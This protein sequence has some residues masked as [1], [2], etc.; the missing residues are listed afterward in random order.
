MDKGAPTAI[1]AGARTRIQRALPNSSVEVADAWIG[2]QR[3]AG[4]DMSVM[5]LAAGERPTADVEVLAGAVGVAE[6]ELARRMHAA[7]ASGSLPF[8]GPGSMLTARSWSVSTARRLARAG[9]LAAEHPGLAQVWASGIITS[10]HV[11]AVARHSELFTAEELAAVIAELG[12]RWGRWSPAAITRFVRAADRLLHPRAADPEPNESDAYATRGLSFAVTSD[13]VILSGELPR[14]EGELVMAA[15]EA[16]AEKLRSTAEHVPVSARR[17]D[18]L[19]ELVNAAHAAGA[20]PTRGGLPVALTVTL[21]H[22]SRGDPIWSTGRGHL[23]TEA[24]ARFTACDP[25]ITPVLFDATG[26]R[27]ATTCPDTVEDLLAEVERPWATQTGEAGEHGYEEARFGNG[28]GVAG[29]GGS[30]PGSAPS[31]AARVAALASAMLDSRVPIAVGRTERTAT[32]AQRR[33]LAARDKGCV[34][35][36]CGVTAEACQVHHV[37]EWSAGGSTDPDNLVLVCW[38]HHRQVDLLMWTIHPAD[39]LAP[40]PEP[41]RGSPPGTTWPANNGAPW[42]VRATPRTRWRM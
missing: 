30:V 10:E 29:D 35:P 24:E 20:L 38:A 19:V 25:A 2:L 33:V 22:T 16:F 41:D 28:G 21:D 17:A 32:S 34:I 18:A 31:M 11:D 39:P 6:Y 27:E 14:L 5:G 26:G 36:G 9:A 13:S 37:T 1:R 15:I 4:S 3:S 7:Q 8:P 12:S 42:T 40:V 23:L